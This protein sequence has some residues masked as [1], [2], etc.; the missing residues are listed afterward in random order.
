MRKKIN[1]GK[2]VY[3]RVVSSTPFKSEPKKEHSDFIVC[4]ERKVKEPLLKEFY[5]YEVTIYS[6]RFKKLINLIDEMIEIGKK[7]IEGDKWRL[8]LHAT[9]FRKE[10]IR[11]KKMFKASLVY[12]FRSEKIENEII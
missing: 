3:S 1:I 6:N 11:G 12:K 9:R 2:A 7:V 4:P 10:R 8:S 5:E